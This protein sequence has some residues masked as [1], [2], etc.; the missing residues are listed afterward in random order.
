MRLQN[1]VTMS[2]LNPLE[3]QLKRREYKTQHQNYGT[4][5]ARWWQLVG[6]DHIGSNGIKFAS[7]S[8]LWRNTRFIRPMI[9]A[10]GIG[11]RSASDELPLATS[12]QPI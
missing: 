10:E 11:E 12:Q 3:P 8:V 2:G 6:I 1:F 7:A 5:S 4:R 9:P